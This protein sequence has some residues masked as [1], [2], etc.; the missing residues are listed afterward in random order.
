MG[1]NSKGNAK[2]RQRPTLL[3]FE[4][5]EDRPASSYS[6]IYNSTDLKIEKL[7]LKVLERNIRNI[8]LGL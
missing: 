1:G 3:F 7:D 6:R 8:E 2:V 4:K 5:V